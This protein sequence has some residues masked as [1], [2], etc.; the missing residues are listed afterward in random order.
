MADATAS[1]LS[2]DFQTGDRNLW[3]SPKWFAVHTRG[4]HEK[5]VDER[6]RLKGITTFLPTRKIVRHWSDR[7]KIIQE[8]LFKNYLFVRIPW[9]QRY[10][11]LNTAGMVRF[12][13]PKGARPYIVAERELTSLQKLVTE[14]VPMDPYPYLKEGQRVYVRSGLF[15]GAEGF[16]VHKDKQCRLVLSLDIIFQSISVQI[17]Q[18]CVE[19]A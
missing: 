13:G 7:K 16:I 9:Q 4:R 12:V 8:P 5:A 18:A 14:D 1:T 10:D 15:K 19:P 17:D 6:L 11:V 2:S 3:T